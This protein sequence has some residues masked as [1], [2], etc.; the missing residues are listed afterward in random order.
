MLSAFQVAASVANA[1]SHKEILQN[2]KIVVGIQTVSLMATD[3]E[4]GIRI[5]VDGATIEHRGDA[6]LP[7]ARVGM[8]L[9]ES[10][11]SQIHISTQG[12]E[13]L[14]STSSSNFK[15]PSANPD[16]YPNVEGFK[17]SE[18]HEISVRTLRELIKRT[19]FATDPD[20]SRYAL[21]GVLFEMNG[22]EVFTVGTDGRRMARMIGTGLSVAGHVTKPNH[23]IVPARALGLIAKA[24]S[25]LSDDDTVNFAARANDIVISTIISTVTCRLVE[26]KF[27]NWKNVLPSR[28]NDTKI[29]LPVG[30]LFSAIRQ[31][32]IIADAETHGLDFKFER[33]QLVISAKTANLGTSRVNLP[34]EHSGDMIEMKL[35]FRYVSDF[36][37][38]LASESTCTANL[39][40]SS[41]SLL[42]T[43]DDGYLYVVMPMALER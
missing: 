29:D 14:I 33:S 37:R 43:T 21:S 9:R 15:L 17:E 31:A 16:E 19:S 24:I 6:L 38:M 39:A 12:T 34:I 26:G 32:A 35:D 20:N 30:Q 1:R 2:V 10:R 41:E 23:T 3:M 27:P 7:V 22:D 40:S 18:Y 11:D 8:I 28:K 36:L 4:N 42:L 25:D 5:L 13:T